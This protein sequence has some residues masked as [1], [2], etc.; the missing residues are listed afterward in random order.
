MARRARTATTAALTVTAALLLSACG[1]GSEAKSGDIKGAETGAGSPSASVPATAGGSGPDISVPK[2]LK[3]DLDFDKP[4]DT[5]QSAA[6]TDAQNYL[7]ALVHGL[8]AQNPDD[9]GYQYYSVS[10]GQ[11]AQYAKSQIQ[12]W[13]KGGWTP[14]GTDRYYDGNIT[15]LSGGKRVLV[16]F[17]ENQAK[18]YGKEIKTGKILYTKESLNS[19]LKYS[20]LMMP[21]SGS[22][23]NWKASVI[24]V[25]GKA[26]EC[27]A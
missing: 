20:L 11:A 13:V 16:K 12:S 4:S 21:P 7:R 1:G 25:V 8:A 26:K 27:Q 18:F 19:Y 9:P 24:E 6:L 5:K 3:L 23:T 17:C 14:Y 2:D 10:G 15:T 22:S